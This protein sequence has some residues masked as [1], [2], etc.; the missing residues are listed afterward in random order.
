MKEL[1][2]QDTPAL[3][4]AMGVDRLLIAM[5]EE[6]PPVTDPKRFFIVTPRIAAAPS[7]SLPQLDVSGLL[8][9][10]SIMRSNKSRVFLSAVCSKGSFK[11]SVT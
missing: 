10:R 1:G 9:F 11:S 8:I 7:K 5:P 3:G 4:W 6:L 2:G